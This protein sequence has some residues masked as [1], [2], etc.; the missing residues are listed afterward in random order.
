MASEEYPALALLLNRKNDHI[1]F[2]NPTVKM[3]FISQE[4]F[5]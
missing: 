4:L 1:I 5:P 3:S 2:P